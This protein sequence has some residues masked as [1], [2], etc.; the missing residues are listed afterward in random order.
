MT[1]DLDVLIRNTRR[2]NLPRLR[3]VLDVAGLFVPGMMMTYQAMPPGKW[4]V[5]HTSLHLELLE[6]PATHQAV[7]RFRGQ[8]DDRDPDEPPLGAWP[9]EIDFLV[10]I[11]SLEVTAREYRSP[12]ATFTGDYDA[13]AMLASKLHRLYRAGFYLGRVTVAKMAA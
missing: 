6:R 1:T 8:M 12:G 4:N 2:R 3:R 9:W 11:K 13:E 10:D 5:Y 7:V